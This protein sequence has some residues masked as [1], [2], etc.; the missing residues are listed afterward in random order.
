MSLPEPAPEVDR[1]AT[2]ARTATGLLREVNELGLLH[3]ADVHVARRLGAVAGEQDQTV[4]LAVALA[5]RAVRHGSVVLELSRVEELVPEDA[6]D[7]GA[8]EPVPV[9]WPDPGA[10]LEAL[11]RSPLTVEHPPGTVEED[12]SAPLHLV[13]D[14]LWLDRY[15]R[16]ELAVARDLRARSTAVAAF[17]PDAAA[18]VLD[19]LWPG[20]GLPGGADDQRAAAAVCLAHG[21]SVLAGGPGTGKTTTVARLLAAVRALSG[22]TVRVALAAPTGK[23]AARLTEAVVEAAATGVF[24]DTERDFLRGVSASTLHRLLGIRPGSVRARFDA[25]HRLPHDV[26]IVDEASM[27]GLGV[28]ARLLAALRPGARLILVGDPQQLASVEVGNVLA[29]LTADPTANPTA[30]PTADLIAGRAR[31]PHGVSHLT[32]THRFAS[33]GGIAAIAQAVRDARA[34]EVVDLLRAGGPDVEFLEVPDAEV[35]SG[36]ALDVVRADVLERS[37]A[38][39]EAAVA[40]DADAALAALDTHRLLCAHRR[41]TRGVS[42]WGALA[43]R[44]AVEELGVVPRTDGRYV[45]LPVIVTANDPGTGV[46]NGDTGVVLDDGGILVAAI[47]RG[48][49]PLRVPLARLA[50][51]EPVHAMTVHRSQGSQFETVTVLAA[52]ERSPLATREMFYTALTRARSRVRVV[53]SAA[54]VA[55]AVNRPL[56]RATG[57]ADRLQDR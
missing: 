28:M 30:D 8:V 29:D 57:L 32:R 35:V 13:G 38:V 9:R 27:V 12:R 48:P 50:A 24:T 17:D 36:A 37:R 23:A 56:A 42:H 14:R 21:V 55:A 33:G 2:V 15:W 31:T 46:F 10:W 45:G 18:A 43:H 20:D 7:S 44:W 39:V 26:V 25:G 6:D 49:G 52:P 41:G 22:G 1:S 34:E 11:R 3:A 40:G 51:F 16:Q 19:R 54:A 53:G 4:L 5:V 47:A